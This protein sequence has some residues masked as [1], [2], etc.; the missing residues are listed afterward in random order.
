MA[1]WRYNGELAPELPKWAEDYQ[2]VTLHTPNLVTSY[3]LAFNEVEIV[4]NWNITYNYWHD[5]YAINGVRSYL[6]WPNWGAPEAFSSE[7]VVGRSPYRD[8][9][10]F[11]DWTS[12]DLYCK[13]SDG[14]RYRIKAASDPVNAETGAAVKWPPI[15]E[16]SVSAPA[17][18]F[19]WQIQG[20]I[21]G[22]RLAGMRG[23]KQEI[24]NTARLGLGVLG[25]MILGKE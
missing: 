9:S 18:R 20:W 19:H 13:H 11:A 21:V 7:W 24:D 8:F 1:N 6:N 23:Q 14:V 10:Y 12:R 4:R 22:K 16:L 3:I 15:P 17:N 2:Y 25:R 5:T